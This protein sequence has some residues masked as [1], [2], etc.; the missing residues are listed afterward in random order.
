MRT[1]APDTIN[2]L[3]VLRERRD[4]CWGDPLKDG[5]QRMWIEPGYVIRED[6]EDGND[7]GVHGITLVFAE[8]RGNRAV[9]TQFYLDYNS[10]PDVTAR[11]ARIMVQFPDMYP[12]CTGLYYHYGKEPQDTEFMHHVTDCQMNGEICWGELGSSLYGEKITLRLLDEG[13]A[14]IWAE[15]DRAFKEDFD[16][17]EK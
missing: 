17:E 10:D 9:D 8:R 7:Y 6:P 5:E 14:G 16:R 1:H 3:K 11:S 4:K 13:S 2:S 12:I 15:F